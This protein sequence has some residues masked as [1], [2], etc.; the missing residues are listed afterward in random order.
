ML[1]AEAYG[2]QQDDNMLMNTP[3]EDHTTRKIG[4]MQDSGL[5]IFWWLPQDSQRLDTWNASGL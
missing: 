3:K 1:L 2:L 4:T 5:P